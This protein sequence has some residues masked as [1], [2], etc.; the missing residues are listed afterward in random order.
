MHVL[1]VVVEREAALIAT[2]HIP[3][4]A[5]ILSD[6]IGRNFHDRPATRALD[7]KH[8]TT[9]LQP[10]AATETRSKENR[11]RGPVVQ[12]IGQNNL[13]P[14]LLDGSLRGSGR[15]LLPLLVD[16]GMGKIR[17]FHDER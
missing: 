13:S 3:G 4:V 16:P 9:S 11:K 15:A 6:G 10:S 5:A 14:I 8:Q 7:K 12:P 1:V 17:N 2:G